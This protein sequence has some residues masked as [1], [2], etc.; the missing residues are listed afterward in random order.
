MP[1]Q[2]I[3]LKTA[4]A[5]A[6]TVMVGGALGLVALSAQVASLWADLQSAANRNQADRVADLLAERASS[7][8]SESA[9][10]AEFQSSLSA[11]PVDASGF[12]CLLDDQATVLCH[13]DPAAV[14]MP[15]AA[16]EV[17]DADG[18]PA[19][20]LGARAARHREGALRLT[21][22]TFGGADHLVYQRPVDGTRWLVSVH[23]N[24]GVI[25]ERLARLRHTMLAVALP[26]G[27]LLVVVGTV[28]VRAVARRYER[29]I[30]AA[31]A[32]LEAAVARRTEDL[33]AT[34]EELRRAREVLEQNE[35]LAVVGESLAG[36]THELNGQLTVIIGHAALGRSKDRRSD[37]DACFGA[38]AAAGDRCARL[39]RSF[40]DFV[41]NHP[42]RREV[43]DLDR[44]V[45]AAVTIC[46][47][48]FRQGR[49]ELRHELNA[50]SQVHVDPLHIEQVIVNLVQNARQAIEGRARPGGVVTVRSRRTGGMA[51][52]LVADDGPGVPPSM[53]DRLFEPF[54]TSK[55]AGVGTGLGL[56]LCRRFVNAHGGSIELL[57][58]GPCGTTFR[59]ELP[60]VGATP[61]DALAVDGAD[62]QPTAAASRDAAS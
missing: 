15:M 18:S 37:V 57:E 11:A 16:V 29:R 1:N 32:G 54:Q 62:P 50:A 61:A 40:L 9:V 19:G 55:P 13:P 26:V 20:T 28:A 35:K 30:E 58:T 46:A 4:A 12:L 44:L 8:A 48:S 5:L 39:V 25:T 41:R 47:P 45:V 14:G 51:E 7:G 36:L 38:I 3:V 2:K 21:G 49:I 24:Q 31:N 56:S 6:A 33:S 53:R 43:V 17:H 10:L 59:V 52:L 60:V 27:L 22:M 42:P 23:A 34:V